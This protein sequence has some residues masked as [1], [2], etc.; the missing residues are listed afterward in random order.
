M[1]YRGDSQRMV[2]LRDRTVLVDC[3]VVLDITVPGVLCGFVSALEEPADKLSIELERHV[4]G[5]SPYA[6]DLGHNAVNADGY[7]F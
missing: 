4:R 1:A 5:R 7:P 2:S 3:D 6:A